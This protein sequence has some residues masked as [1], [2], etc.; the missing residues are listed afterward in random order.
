VAATVEGVAEML[1]L[2]IAEAG[3]LIDDLVA[4]GML[5]PIGEQ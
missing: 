5:A 2:E 3:E 1:G 4:A